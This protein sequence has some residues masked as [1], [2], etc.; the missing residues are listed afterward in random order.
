MP[1]PAPPARRLL[2]SL[3]A[4]ALALG[5]STLATFLALTLRAEVAASATLK[6]PNLIPLASSELRI[7]TV[8]SSHVACSGTR[9]EP[10]GTK[11]L[12]FTITSWNAG[13]GPLELRPGPAVGGTQ[14][15]SQRVYNTDG[16]FQDY[17]AGS[18]DYH[19]SHNHVHFDDYAAYTLR[20]RGIAGFD[21]DTV[22]IKATFC[23]IDTDHIAPLLEGSPSSA[24]YRSC[25]NPTGQVIPQG[26]SVGWGDSYR[27]HLDGQSVILDGLPN[28]PYRL[29]IDVDPLNLIRE[30]DDKDNASSICF[31]I[32]GNS[33][34]NIVAGAFCGDELCDGIDND[35][36]NDIDEFF[37]D[38]DTD[39]VADCVDTDDDGDGYS[40]A[41]EIAMGK[42]PLVWCAAMRADVV[43]TEG[44]G[45]TV[46]IL[47]LSAVAS[48]YGQSIPPATAR[49]DQNHDG[50][51]G[52][53]DLSAVAG[54]FGASVSSCP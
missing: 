1:T 38:T 27:Y 7:D 4:F 44:A 12:C 36:D 54:Q 39:G 28:G 22:G 10:V 9:S 43:G 29:I 2:A 49:F 42:N 47:D 16:T 15:V 8:N 18:M 17:L 52:I 5:L 11:L 26:M 45:G 46:S 50:S 3:L 21:D 25:G 41:T 35:G 32:N 13:T 24:Q 53:L 31:R 30:G 14:P 37:P 33:V 6:L 48:Q 20:P 34:T 40:D 51:I 19:P 23:I